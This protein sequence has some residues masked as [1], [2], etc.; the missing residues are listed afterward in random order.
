M[1]DYLETEEMLSRILEAYGDMQHP[2][3]SFMERRYQELLGHPFV[4]ELMADCSVR[5]VTDLNDHAALHL[6]VGLAANANVEVCLSFVSNYAMVFRLQKGSRVYQS[7][8]TRS[9]PDLHKL[10]MK[11]MDFLERYDFRIV[12]RQEAATPIRM[13]LFETDLQD[14][15]I[16]HALISDCGIIPS[17]LLSS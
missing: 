13:Q 15:T 6:L 14:T 2:D 1:D 4:N 10:E 17:V 7:V 8:V 12:S 5:D 16:Y 3:C 9:T 11:I